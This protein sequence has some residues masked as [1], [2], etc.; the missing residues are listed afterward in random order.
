MSPDRLAD[1][2][3]AAVF[4]ALAIPI[5]YQPRYG[6]SVVVRAV[7]VCPALDALGGAWRTTG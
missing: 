7:H 3:I 6:D 1:L 5:T 4:D 2:A